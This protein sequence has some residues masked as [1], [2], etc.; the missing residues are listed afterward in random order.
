MPE[1]ADKG[2]ELDALAAVPPEEQ[3]AA[4]EAVKSGST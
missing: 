2:V 1:I 3:K 4:V